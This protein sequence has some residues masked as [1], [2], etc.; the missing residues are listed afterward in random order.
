MSGLLG[1]IV[2][3]RFNP[4]RTSGAFPAGLA[5]GWERGTRANSGALMQNLPAAASGLLFC[6]SAPGFICCRVV[7]R[8]VQ[9]VQAGVI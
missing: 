9:S 3:S 6:F 1:L 5:W 4:L 2:G 7:T 8:Y